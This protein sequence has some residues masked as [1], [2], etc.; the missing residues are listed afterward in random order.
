MNTK[1]HI[2]R[3]TGLTSMTAIRYFFSIQSAYADFYRER[4]EIS[5]QNS[6]EAFLEQAHKSYADL[7]EKLKLKQEPPILD[8]KLYNS[9][10]KILNL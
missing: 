5:M 4:K 8:V 7:K 10:T 1:I 6:A 9:M 3:E 2:N